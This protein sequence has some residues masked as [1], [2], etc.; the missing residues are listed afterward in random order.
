[1]KFLTLGG[2]L[3]ALLSAASAEET[4]I[5]AQDTP[6]V[7][8]PETTPLLNADQFDTTVFDYKTNKM[9]TDKGTFV[10]FYAPWCGHCKKLAP[11]WDQAFRENK[12][13]NFIKIDCTDDASKPVCTEMFNVRGY[14]T[15]YFLKDG[16]SYEYKGQRKLAA[17]VE[18]AK[19]KHL[20]FKDDAV[21]IPRRRFGM[22][23]FIYDT[24][25]EA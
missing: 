13:I 23:K 25:R 4:V 18:F 1:M 9:L 10:K 11:E 8:E 19:E 6:V 14:P 21:L 22:E 20:E 17:I 15:L 24:K 12:D 3:L 16:L 2:A 7:S 5:P